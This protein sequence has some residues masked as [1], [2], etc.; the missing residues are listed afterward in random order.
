L[1]TS[2]SDT[3]L[4]RLRKSL[5]SDY[6]F[7]PPSIAVWSSDVGADKTLADKLRAVEGVGVVS[8][9]RFAPSS[10]VAGA[11]PTS[12]ASGDVPISLL[13]IDPVAFPQVAS[14]GFD[15]GEPQVTYSELA[16]GRTIIANGILAANTHVKIGDTLKLVTPDGMQDYRVIA[17]AGD[18]LN[19]KVVTGYI[20]QANLAADFHVT[21]D[22]FIQ[23]N[24]AP[25][26]DRA[27]V[28]PR[29]QAVADEYPQFRFIS[30]QA[31]Y[32]ENA[33][34]F[35]QAFI[36]MYILFGMLALPSLISILNTL[37]IGVIERTREIGMLRAVGATQKQVRRMVLAEA[38]LL[39][40]TG[41]IFGLL[42]GVYL[43]YLMI[44]AMSSAGYPMS[45]SFPY[46]GIVSALAVG[47]FFGVVA[48]LIPA[49]QAARLEIV[50]ALRYE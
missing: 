21:E 43:S 18:Y 49:R 27:V 30:G 26:V 29:L 24:L 23:L 28:E 34:A 38:V 8:T 42:G 13:G 45:F 48:A 35:S 16:N 7:I 46:L 10:T 9:M 20:S 14:L 40:T 50:Q 44:G 25:G 12:V 2:V 6:L 4:T 1:I 22:I 41:T 47:L 3:F 15:S 19:A 17:I 37:A 31:Y 5:G 11:A 32:E 33:K 39:A 36:S